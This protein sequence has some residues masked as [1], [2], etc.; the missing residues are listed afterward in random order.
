MSG[1]PA[2]KDEAGLYRQLLLSGLITPQDVV[3]WADRQILNLGALP[4]ALVDLS[5]SGGHRERILTALGE[6]GPRELSEAGFGLYAAWL[7]S[8]L[9]AEPAQLFFVT[10]ALHRLACQDEA[11]KGVKDRIDMLDAQ[12]HLAAKLPYIPVSKVEAEVRKFLEGWAGHA[13]TGTEPQRPLRPPVQF[14]PHLGGK[15]PDPD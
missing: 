3:A 2:L 14:P 1:V 13:P 5:L 6:L 12:L 11:P 9:R 7:L 10:R 15:V 8:L 4:E